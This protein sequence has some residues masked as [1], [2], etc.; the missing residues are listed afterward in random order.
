MAQIPS[1]LRGGEILA[2]GLGLGI[3]TLAVCARMYTKI[4]LIGTMLKEDCGFYPCAKCLIYNSVQLKEDRFFHP[5]LGMM[6]IDILR[7]ILMQ[8]RSADECGASCS[9]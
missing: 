4:R 5:F 9:P 3:S 6:S 7:D 8:C 1:S 2:L